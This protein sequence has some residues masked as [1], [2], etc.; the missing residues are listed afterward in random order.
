M[1]FQRHLPHLVFLY[2]IL[3]SFLFA[4]GKPATSRDSDVLDKGR[5]ITDG[6]TLVSGGGTFTLGFF[7]PAGGVPSKRYLG[8]WFSFSPDAVYWVANGDHP[9]NDTSGVLVMS[10]AG[11]LVLLDSSGRKEVW[12]SGSTS[13]P[14]SGARLLESGNLVVYGQDSGTALWQSFDH[15]CN[16]LLP[17]MK[18]GKNLWTGAH[19]Y[20]VSWRSATDPAPGSYRYVTDTFGGL[21]ENVILDGNNTEK[22]RTGPWNGKRFS[23]VPEMASF[24]D[25]FTYQLTVSPSEVT[26]S[27]AAKPGA[28]YSRVVVTEA[29]VVQRLVWD[30]S[31]RAW[32][33]FFKAP[34]DDC[35]GYAKCGAFGLCDSNK[36]ATSLCSCVRGFSPVT[37]S[38]WLMR[39]YSG[40]CRRN[41]ALDCSNR[42]RTIVNTSDGFEVRRGVKLPDT[43][44]ASVDMSRLARSEIVEQGGT[45]ESPNNTPLIV[46]ASVGTAAAIALILFL[47][48]A[49]IRRKR[50]KVTCKPASPPS[51]SPTGPVMDYQVLYDGTD[52]FSPSKLIG[53]GTFGKVYECLLPDNEATRIEQPG[54]K[55]VAVKVLRESNRND[56]ERELRVVFGLKHVNLVRLLAYCDHEMRDNRGRQVNTHILVYEFMPRKSLNCYIF[57]DRIDR[58]ILNWWQRLD[59]IYSIAEGIHYVHVQSGANIIHRDLKPGN[60]LLDDNWTPKIADFGFAKPFDPNPSDP[61]TSVVCFGYSAPE[62][63]QGNIT[64]KCDVY[65]FGVVLL[66]IISGVVNGRMQRLLPHAWEYWYTGNTVELLDPAVPPSREEAE[67][68]LLARLERNIQ[69]GL[70]CVQENHE[71]R[72]HIS[73]IVAMLKGQGPLLTQP[74]RPTLRGGGGE[75]SGTCSHTNYHTGSALPV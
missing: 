17:G 70:L 28:P 57:G 75:T 39:E 15:P 49:V 41:V 60:I 31:T 69:I 72:P 30:T 35:D 25:M 29:G 8:I 12:S 10:D 36:G 32:K 68:E 64:L 1:S 66:E 5:N 73:D 4:P 14:A 52:E 3:S 19:W 40:G 11:S 7:S 38:E 16:T 22:Y 53:Q 26:Y 45:N 67:P 24:A 27:Y 44:D 51:A 37:P 9:L 34:R 74:V 50:K 18:I 63:W 43:K 56:Y 20:V 13:S 21:P 55:T 47:V 48:F 61:H 65:S 23:G 58:A 6:D 33:T 59:I 2:I 62:C 46:G 42:S 54:K 71:L